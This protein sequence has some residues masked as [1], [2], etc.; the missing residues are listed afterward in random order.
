MSKEEKH[1]NDIFCMKGD[2]M[3]RNGG[4]SHAKHHHRRHHGRCDDA[5]TNIGNATVQRKMTDTVPYL[6]ETQAVDTVK[7]VGFLIRDYRLAAL[8]L[9]IFVSLP[10]S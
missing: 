5:T 1:L 9:G 3:I 8:T 7:L 2:A 4:T 10:I 6:A